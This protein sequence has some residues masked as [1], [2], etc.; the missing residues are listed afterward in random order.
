MKKIFINLCL[1]A[2]SCVVGLLLCEWTARLLL[3]PADFLSVEM[4]PDPILGRIPS[5]STRDSGFDDWGFR[6][7][8]VP[9]SAEIVAI[10]DS[11]TFGNTAKM[12]E[13]WPHVLGRLTGK[14]VYNMGL[15]G[16]GPNQYYHLLKTGGIGLKPRVIIYGL[17]MGDDFENAF[18]ITYGLDHWASLRQ[19]PSTRADFDIWDVEESPS[20]HK[21]PRVWLSAHS[22][23]YKIVFHGPVLGRMKGT[24]QI[25]NASKLYDSATSLII[26]EEHIAEA[27]LPKSMLPR[28]NQDDERIKEGMRITFRILKETNDI[29][30]QNHIQFLVAVIPTKETVFA[31]YLEHNSKV[32]LSDIIDKHIANERLA[33]EATFQFFADAHIHFVDTL[34]ALKKSVGYE[35]YTHIASDMHPNKNGYKVIAEAIALEF[36]KMERKSS[37]A[38]PTDN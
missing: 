33:R 36:E 21:K 1:I 8:K 29:C 4:V 9:T 6:N 13:S 20:W 10:G 34:P 11:H 32:N 35:I 5:K 23:L 22:V 14:T 25:Q 15:G 2:S 18:S 19:L 26:P 28:L 7:S 30:V 12:D 24:I 31:N 37:A 3:N 27:F 17:Y 16:Y 38:L